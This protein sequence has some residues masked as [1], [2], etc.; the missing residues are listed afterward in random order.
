MLGA[1][2]PGHP[3]SVS[4]GYELSRL[5]LG[6]VQ[7]GKGNRRVFVGRPVPISPA[8]AAERLG[9]TATDPPSLDDQQCVESWVEEP[10]RK[11][12]SPE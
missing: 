2:C 3:P 4:T 8:A 9:A 10:Y 12:G 7:A 11:V 6:Y 5:K 1:E